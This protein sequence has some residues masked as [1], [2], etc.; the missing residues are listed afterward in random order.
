MQNLVKLLV[1]LSVVA[2]IVAVLEVLIPGLPLLG[3]AESYSRLSNNLA[4]IAI[5]TYFCCG[6]SSKPAH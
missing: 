4:L 2:L 6:D 1:F 3:A 5:A